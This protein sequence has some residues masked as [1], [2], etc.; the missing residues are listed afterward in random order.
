MEGQEM[1]QDMGKRKPKRRP[2]PSVRL[3]EAS[4]R[5]RIIQIVANHNTPDSTIELLLATLTQQQPSNK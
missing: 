1:T 2:P 5:L 4:K 3:A